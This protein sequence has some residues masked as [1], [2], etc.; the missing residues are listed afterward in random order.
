MNKILQ[1]KIIII[2]ISILILIKLK[3]F[4][5]I[6]ILNEKEIASVL[7]NLLFLVFSI[8]NNYKNNKNN[9]YYKSQILNV[10]SIFCIIVLTESRKLNFYSEI[11]ITIQGKGT[12]QI[13]SNYS[14]LCSKKTVHFN[15]LPEVILLN[16]DIH[17]IGKYAYNL[18]EEINE[19]TMIWYDELTDC[20]GMFCGLSNI[21]KIDFSSFDGSKLTD[22]RCMFADCYSLK[23]LDLRRFN[24]SLIEDMDSVFKGLYSLTSLDISSFD[25]S[26]VKNMYSSFSGCQSLTSINIGHFDTSKV[27]NMDHLFFYC[28]KLVSLNLD[29]FNTSNVETFIGMVEGCEELTS[30][31]L[32]N[33]NTSKCNSMYAMFSNCRALISL[34]LSDFNTISVTSMKQMFQNCY[35]LKSLDISN[36]NTSNVDD[37]EEMFKECISLQSL[38]IY[39]FDTSKV[40][41][42]TDMFYNIN[43]NLILCANQEKQSTISS[44]FSNLNNNCSYFCLSNNQ[45][46]FI[47]ETNECVLNCNESNLYKYEYNNLC[48]QNCPY[49][50]ISSN[51]DEFFCIDKTIDIIPNIVS[52]IIKTTYIE[53]YSSNTKIENSLIKNTN[54]VSEIIKTT[55][56]EAYSTNTKI[57]NSIIK[58]TN[59]QTNNEILN[60]ECNIKNMFDKKCILNNNENNE[61]NEDSIINKIRDEIKNGDLDTLIESIIKGKNE[62][63]VIK[64]NNTVYQITSSSI[65]SNKEYD[66]ISIIKLG[67]CE[68]RLRG[69]YEIDEDDPLLIL[70]IDVQKEGLL[71]PSVEYEVY[72]IESKRKLELDVCDETK[73]DILLPVSHVENDL[74]KHNTSS[75]YY[76]DI[77]YTY[78]TDAKTDIILNDRKKEFINNN[79]TLCD[80][81]CEYKGYDANTKMSKCE[82]SPKNEIPNI[83][84]ISFDKEKFLNKFV[85]INNIMNIKLLKCYKLLF[86][87]EGIIKN[88]GSYIIL[89][90]IIISIISNVIFLFKGFKKLCNIIEK[91]INFRQNM[92][93]ITKSQ[94]SQKKTK[95]EKTKNSIKQKKIKK[96]KKNNKYKSKK[97]SKNNFSSIIKSSPPKPKI[98]LNRNI[99]KPKKEEMPI[100]SKTNFNKKPKK[101]LSFISNNN[102]DINNKSKNE[103]ANEKELKDLND[104]ELNTLKYKEAL[105]I[106]K[107]SYLEY[108]F[109]L[110]KRKQK[111]IFTFYTTDDY[112]SRTIKICLFFFSFT[113]IYTVN[114][115]FFSDSSMHK[116]Y[117]DNGKF[118]FIYQIPQILYS[119][120]ISSIINILVNLLSLSE[121]NI[122]NLKKDNKNMPKKKLQTINCL[123]IKF[124]IFY[125]LVYFFLLLFWYYLSCFCAVYKNTQLYLIKDSFISFVLSLLYPFGISLLPGLLRIPS[126]KSESRNNELL[127]KASQ[128]VQLI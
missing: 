57:E 65:E 107:R 87:K 68:D 4:K 34:D 126:L 77:C 123:K 113:L 54:I 96:T 24:T 111:L 33:F 98:A 121:R 116:I 73:I 85:D 19:V 86:T 94:Y 7:Q 115:L 105:L 47:F 3:K 5:S 102:N 55:Y 58:N 119:T 90:I 100:N 41:K 92:K 18:S 108:Y 75:E 28:R 49:G 40:N 114:A 20:S 8:Y 67:D 128:Y 26:K 46:K 74:F 99:Y 31:N 43:N 66:N 103:K 79:L 63:L 2:I 59:I 16:G 122:I 104:Q 89:F 37:M 124:I 29:N 84:D 52:T 62:D 120:I 44:L 109:S 30:I 1:K 60:N 15:T 9:S 106:D 80:P 45:Q 70:K 72:D 125:I 69:K 10:F 117:E 95:N 11:T 6:Y 23:S 51:L 61:I 14:D 48:Y 127:Y 78:T 32:R 25:T 91:I 101:N 42:L 88:I 93:N 38:N 22:I 17:P 97:K 50:S 12:Q 112:N 71:I 36:F 35:S 21:I 39:N 27:T 110:L 118:N 76:K 13:L 53:A 56:I 64:D 83:S 81:N 82:C